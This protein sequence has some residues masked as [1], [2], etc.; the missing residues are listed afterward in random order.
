MTEPDAPAPQGHNRPPPF[1]AEKREAALTRAREIADTA[2]AWLDLSQ[3][4]TEAQSQMLTDFV[5]GARAVQKEIDAE[6][7]AQKRPHDDA[8]NAVQEAYRLPLDILKRVLD[9]AKQLQGDW[10]IRERRRLEEEQRAARIEAERIAAEARA[11][12]AR[13]IAANDL[14]G[15]AEAEANRA[16]A[17]KAEKAAAREVKAKAGS[18]T[19]GGR[20][21]SLRTQKFAE[22]E[23]PR[24]VFMHFQSDPAVIDL[25]QRLA[26]AAIRRG[27]N[28]PGAKSVDR[29]VAA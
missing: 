25:L 20:T 21:M 10:L 17:E 9:R 15:L 4:E 6:R 13:S 11:A 24:A 1:D 2:G 14:A 26:T 3:I 12:E 22:I 28:V 8:A 18:Y 16:A 5:A 29:E 19:G 27:E 23:N 7:V